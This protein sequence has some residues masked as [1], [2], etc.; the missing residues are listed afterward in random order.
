[1]VDRPM[2][3]PR[4]RLW[5]KI[6]A[7]ALGAVAC[8]TV[9]YLLVANVLL[10]TRLLRNAIST[11]FAVSNTSSGLLFDYRSAYSVLPGRVHLE[12]VSIRGRDRTVEW[13]LTL[14]RA[15]VDVSLLA[16]VHR[17]FRA[18][19]LRAS[20]FTMRARF[21]LT[22]ADA[23]PSVVA[24]LPPITGFTDPPLLEIGPEPPPL[25]EADYNLWTLDFPD[26]DV[27]GVRELWIHT[28]RA[29][30]D[31]RARGRWFFRPQR[32]LDVGPARVD[33]NGV[34]V[35]YGK[36]PLARTVTGSFGASVHPFDVQ[37]VSGSALFDRISY[38]GRLRGRA[39]FAG[40]LRLLVPESGVDFKRFEAPFDAR[41]VLSHGKLA[42]ETRVRTEPADAVLETRGLTLDVPIRSALAVDDGTATL[43]TRI[44]G[45]RIS[46][47]GTEQ[48]RV[49]SVVAVLSSGQLRL[50]RLFEDTRF[51]LDVRGAETSDIGNW[52]SF[53]PSTRTLVHSGLVSA[54]GHADGSL[55]E[56]RGRAELR[57]LVRRLSVAR[58]RERFTADITS[59]ARIH[60]GSL[61]GGWGVGT[62]TIAADAV[63]LRL[64]RAVITG[65]LDA[66]VDLR[67]GT[68]ASKT[69]DLSGTNVALRALAVAS[70]QS[71]VP[72][73]LVPSLKAVAPRFVLAPAGADG[74]VS[75]DLPRADV[76]ALARLHELL[77]LP[78]GLRFE[79]G[80]AR[81]GLHIDVELATGSMR[82]ESAVT[83]R[84]LRARVGATTFF[85]DVAGTVHARRTPGAEG[86]TDL[87]GSTLAITRASTGEAVRR[88][89][90]WWGNVVL[91][92]ATLRTSGD[93]QFNAK[94]HLTAKDATPATVL[95]AQNTGVPSWA[96]NVFRMP[97]LDADAAMRLSEASLE[98]RSFVA[99]GGGT[100]LRAE[101]AKRDERQD[102]A[103]L[104][105][106]GW[107]GLGYDLADGSIGLVL[108]GPERWFKRKVASM[109]DASVAAERQTDAT[110]EVARYTA[111]TP[112]LRESEAGELAGHCTLDM[113]T[114]D[115]T[116]I[117]SLLRT[118]ADPGERGALRGILYAP[119][120]VAAAKHGRDGAELDPLVIG[121]LTE[122]L[123]LGG[124]S[125]LANV[126]ST[127]RVV[128]ANEPDSA[129]GKLVAVAGRIQTIRREGACSVGTLTTDAEPIYF[130]TPFP[131][132]GPET[133]SRFRGVFVQRYGPLAPLGTVPAA[134][135]LVGAFEAQ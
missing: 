15:E 46:H 103:V 122:A 102:G 108:I 66:N 63:A 39:I 31:T 27:A 68:W 18:T 92:E 67:R 65:S 119:L 41:I 87:S 85:G 2:R 33:V 36:E 21:R 76:R 109:R 38:D 44:S 101:Y 8:L 78:A 60:D 22:S 105:D 43:D 1:M 79:G 94:A 117:E 51:A 50:A 97:V 133:L 112:E 90:A 52:K 32:W 28:L 88:E 107:T 56:M 57:L 3:G 83:L 113:R 42:S 73:V 130:V 49:A 34:D 77:T 12:G 96:T 59:H 129:R 24:A 61:P 40:A 64:D 93:I 126:P 99:R 118:A 20:G 132:R 100:S 16:L 58:G 86:A 29:K 75:I 74:R 30:G 110:K 135:V 81:A 116:A 89:D 47:V 127:T 11:P 37:R 98:V 72:I 10:R 54:D 69:L 19:R 106:L 5:R 4:S 114:C 115:D 62:A 26:V 55:G 131:V 35:F 120:V 6:A 7:I 53:F 48:A 71:D 9:A 45:L 128:A 91:R 14:D 111:M 82:G 25:T 23:T 13:R 104:M 123:S 95:V 124:E 80:A 70:E 17:T 121:S 125:T 84:G 134:L